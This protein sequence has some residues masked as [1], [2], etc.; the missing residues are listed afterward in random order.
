MDQSQIPVARSVPRDKTVYYWSA[1]RPDIM[2]V[3]V[4]I[5]STIISWR[6]V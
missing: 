4:L 5:A 1:N 3:V 2:S 6:M